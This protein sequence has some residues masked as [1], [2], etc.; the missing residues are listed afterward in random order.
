MDRADEFAREAAER[1]LQ[2][3][4]EVQRQIRDHQEAIRQYDLLQA[5]VNEWV[6]SRNQ[7]AM[8]AA[9]E[10]ERIV[11]EEERLVDGSNRQSQSGQ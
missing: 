2:R 8:Q 10:A 5:E 3:D 11:E 9:L 7:V 1:Q 4:Q 6:E